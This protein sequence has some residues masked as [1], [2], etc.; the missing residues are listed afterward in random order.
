MNSGPPIGRMH[1]APYRDYGYV[2]PRFGGTSLGEWEHNNNIC[3]IA[4]FGILYASCVLMLIMSA[5]CVACIKTVSG[6]K[7]AVSYDVC[8][9]WRQRLCGTG[10]VIII[11]FSF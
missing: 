6:R 3:T 9:R 4:T 7:H 2:P 1:G 8:D 5:L 10:K 11:L